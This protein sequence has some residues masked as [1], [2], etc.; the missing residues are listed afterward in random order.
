[1]FVPPC[2]TLVRGGYIPP[3]DARAPCRYG[4]CSVRDRKAYCGGNWDCAALCALETL[5]TA[6]TY[7]KML[8]ALNHALNVLGHIM[9]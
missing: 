9:A 6:V 8:L 3:G 2:E 4:K 5:M 7:N 1:M